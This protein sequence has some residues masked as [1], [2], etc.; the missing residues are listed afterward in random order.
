MKSIEQARHSASRYN[1]HGLQPKLP[2]QVLTNRLRAVDPQF[3]H[4]RIADVL[5]IGRGAVHRFL[6]DGVP[7]RRADEFACRLG[8]H[9]AEVWG[10]DWWALGSSWGDDAA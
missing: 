8:M 6:R 7:E 9:P 2:M 5:E 3:N 4:T 10:D 1:G